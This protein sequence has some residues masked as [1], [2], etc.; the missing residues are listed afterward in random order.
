M[1]WLSAAGP[2]CTSAAQPALP[3]GKRDPSVNTLETMIPS[4]KSPDSTEDESVASL[5]S[6]ANTSVQSGPVSDVNTVVVGVC[7][8]RCALDSNCESECNDCGRAACTLS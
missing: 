6:D 5:E 4:K 7:H 2:L 8:G 1:H 3:L